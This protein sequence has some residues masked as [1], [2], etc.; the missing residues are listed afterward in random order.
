MGL[1]MQAVWFG[2]LLGRG[3]SCSYN[4]SCCFWEEQRSFYLHYYIYTS[5]KSGGVFGRLITL[6]LIPI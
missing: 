1:G 6:V 5:L 2:Y 3:G 4:D